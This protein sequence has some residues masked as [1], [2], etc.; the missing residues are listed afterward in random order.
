MAKILVTGGAGYIGSHIVNL[1]GDTNHEVIVY[2]NLS[3]GRKESVVAGELV[4]G[5]L[6]DLEKLENLI[7]EKKF[8]ACF[9]FAG[10]IIVPESVTDPLKYYNNNTNN[11]LNLL[12][13]CIKHGVNKF[14]FS[15]TAAVYG[16]AEGGICSEDTVT[17]P[18]NPYGKTKL[19]TEWMLEDIAAAHK[20]FEF[21][22]LRYFNV[23]GA[24]VDG[25]VGQCSPLSTHLIKIACETALGKREKMSV[26]GE[27]YETKDG[28]CIRDYIHVD[29]LAQ[30]HIDSLNYLLK[31][32]ESTLC[33]C[34]YGHGYT[35]KEVIEVVK[36][37]S[38]VDFVAE[39]GP[40][41]AGDAP[42]LTSKAEKIGK[43][44]GW[45]SKYDD[46]EL[47]VRTAYEWEKQLN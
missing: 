33:N 16:M 32:G 17:V 46:L 6:E 26:F 9:H 35:V 40:R 39:I 28:T 36:N 42:V 8:D 11:T 41:R 25:K 24:N 7:V 43:V 20:D 27:D 19:M 13:L 21:V 15:S 37:V 10:S 45:K 5:D 34:G 38:G 4:V 1:L 30:A 29:D 22:I 2:D 14:I 12:N 3:T 23:A 44:L 18:I 31:G 47:I